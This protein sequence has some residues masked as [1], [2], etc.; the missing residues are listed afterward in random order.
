MRRIGKLFLAAAV[1]LV[2]ASGG[3]PAQ[4]NTAYDNDMACRQYADQ[5]VAPMRDQANSQTVGS[6]L[7][8]AGLGAALGAAVGGGR[9]RRLARARAR[10]SAPAPVLPMR[11]M[12]AP[13]SSSNT[14]PIIISACS[15]GAVRRR[16]TRHRS[17]VTARR[18]AT[19]ADQ[20]SRRTG[21][22]IRSACLSAACKKNVQT[23]G[24]RKKQS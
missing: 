20:A 22:E 4:Y 9:A 13:T 2:A 18:P 5:A 12:P 23:I 16:V 3:A 11:R 10:S 14:T 21:A 8:G 7:V 15:S 6:A 1:A 24:R 17:R 19:I